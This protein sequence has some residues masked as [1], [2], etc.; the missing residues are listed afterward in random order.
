[1]ELRRQGRRVAREGYRG[2]S[3]RVMRSLRRSVNASGEPGEKIDDDPCGSG[4]R[5]GLQTFAPVP[6][7]GRLRN[8]HRYP[9]RDAENQQHSRKEPGSE[10]R[11]VTNDERHAGEGKCNSRRNGP[12]PTAEW[13]PFR[14]QTCRAGKELHLLDCIRDI[15]ETE[16]DDCSIDGS[17]KLRG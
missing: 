5:E 8:R 11:F 14:N 12:K 3:S 7:L 1:M 9:N 6:G 17:V 4:N 10:L 2:S 13:N 15:A 16:H